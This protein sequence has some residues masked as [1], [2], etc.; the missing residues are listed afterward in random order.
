MLWRAPVSC[1]GG[2]ACDRHQTNR[3]FRAPCRAPARF[4]HLNDVGC[5]QHAFIGTAAT[6]PAPYRP[7]QQNPEANSR[8]HLDDGGTTLLHHLD[9]LA[10]QVGVIAN[11]LHMAFWW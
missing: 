1:E 8:A 10:V 6:P 11:D 3:G 5:T 4:T 7:Q 9:E 2:V